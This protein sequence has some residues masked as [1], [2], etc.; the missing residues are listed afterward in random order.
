[1]R[2]VY[3][4]QTATSGRGDASLTGQA[5]RK[6]KYTVLRNEN[7]G[8]LLEAKVSSKASSPSC[9]TRDAQAS[10]SSGLSNPSASCSPDQDAVSRRPT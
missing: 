2:Y 8:S 6:V 3:A 9:P 5:R 10:P 7:S 1:M 4:S